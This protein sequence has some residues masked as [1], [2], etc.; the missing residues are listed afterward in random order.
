MKKKLIFLVPIVLMSLYFFSNKYQPF[1]EPKI[2]ALFESNTFDEAQEEYGISGM[3]V[4]QS[5]KILTIVIGENNDKDEI[6]K[7]FEKKLLDIG[8]RDYKVEVLKY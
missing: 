2:E 7:Y 4:G 3:G 1:A 5:E 8:I 6:Q